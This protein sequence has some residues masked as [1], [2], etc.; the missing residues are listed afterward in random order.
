MC[1]LEKY[2]FKTGLPIDFMLKPIVASRQELKTI[3]I[4]FC[5]RRPS[6]SSWFGVWLLD[7]IS[8]GWWHGEGNSVSILWMLRS[9]KISQLLCLCRILCTS[10]VTF[11]LRVVLGVDRVRVGLES[12]SCTLDLLYNEGGTIHCN[13][14]RLDSNRHAGEPTTCVGA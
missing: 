11:G 10:W 2:G 8:G 3:L 14:W 12:N 9:F 6:W 13:L 7:Q 4:S 1:K 5:G